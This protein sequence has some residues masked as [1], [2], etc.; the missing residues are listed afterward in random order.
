[1]SPRL[2]LLR[3]QARR[4]A[5]LP[6]RRQGPLEGLVDELAPG[7]SFAD[8]GAMWNAHGKIAFRAEERGATSV[9]AVDVSP[10]TQEYRNELARR[11]SN[12]RFVHGDLHDDSVR[13]EAGVHDVVWCGGV[14]YH[15][16][17]PIHTLQCL[18]EITKE[19]LVLVS[20]TIPEMP[21]K[22]QG[23]VFFPGLS[24][25]DR[26]AYDRAF[27]LTSRSGAARLGLTMPFDPDQFYGNWWWGLTPSSIRGMLETTGFKVTLSKTD[28][29]H[30]RFVARAV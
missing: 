1:M 28:G 24:E 30:S 5:R 22:A 23:A 17:N 16:P 15:C 26:L 12:V 19:A 3:A 20:A 9:T 11:N 14:L 7:R 4:L 18:R 13:E 29:F 8:I 2:W 27:T 10:P 25:R 21:G 6:F